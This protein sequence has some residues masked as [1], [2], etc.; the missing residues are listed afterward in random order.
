MGQRMEFVTDATI[1]K[2]GAF[3][4]FY[5]TCFDMTARPGRVA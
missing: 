2:L 5:F 4:V 3:V 1:R